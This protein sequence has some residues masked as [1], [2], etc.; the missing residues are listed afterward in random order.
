MP[1]VRCEDCSQPRTVSW[2]KYESHTPI[3]CHPCR[4][5]RR[6]TQERKKRERVPKQPLKW[7]VVMCADGCGAGRRDN[8]SMLPEGQYRCHDCRRKRPPRAV[9]AGCSTEFLRKGANKY[10]ADCIAEGAHSPR[11]WNR[12]VCGHCGAVFAAKF[13]RKHCADCMELQPWKRR[14]PRPKRKK[15]HG[16]HHRARARYFGVEYEYVNPRKV[17]ERDKWRCGICGGPVD[18]TLKYPDPLYAS[19]DH[20]VPMSCGG[21]HSYAN[22]QCSHLKC[23]VDKGNRGGIIQQLALI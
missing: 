14:P 22:T 20:I 19:L 21:A 9:C 7:P 11:V 6:A 16:G 12:R 4:R 3:V 18:Q 15:P 13:K 2:P 10:C 8:P 5:I 23:N 1:S 17:F